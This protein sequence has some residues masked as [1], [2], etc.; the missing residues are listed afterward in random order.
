MWKTVIRTTA[1]LAVSAAALIAATKLDAFAAKP[2]GSDAEAAPPGT[3]R[4]HTSTRPRPAPKPPAP[5]TPKL[6]VASAAM[7]ATIA[8]AA[9]TVTDRPAALVVPDWKGKRL[10]VARREARKL[11]F[12]VK[13]VDESGEPVAASE[14]SAYR[15]RRQLTP[16]GT[17]VQPGDDVEVRVREIFLGAA[18]G[19]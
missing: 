4:P 12:N 2:E 6:T 3:T 18:E 19:Y 8:P 7:P 13:A 11:G 10:S 9:A 14:A 16:A 15:V 1:C 17:E 5:P